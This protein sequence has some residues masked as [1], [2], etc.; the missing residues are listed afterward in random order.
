MPSQL[1]LDSIAALQEESFSAGRREHFLRYVPAPRSGIAPVWEYGHTDYDRARFFIAHFGDCVRYVPD[2]DIWRVWLSGWNEDSTRTRLPAYAFALRKRCM[3]QLAD[4]END[5]MNGVMGSAEASK[6]EIKAAESQI[7]RLKTV[8][9]MLADMANIE[10]MLKAA[11]SIAETTRPEDLWDVDPYCAGTSNGTLNL[12]TRE[13]GSSRFGDYITKYLGAAYRPG[14]T[15]PGW[16]QFLSRV[17]PDEALQNYLQALVGYTL[18]GDV[19]DQGFYFL[20]GKGANG[21]SVFL[22]MIS[23]LMGDYAEQGRRNLLEESRNGDPKHDLA[24]LPG[25]RFLYCEETSA[26]GK[27]REEVLKALTGGEKVVG[28]AKYEKPIVFQPVCKLW[29]AGNHRPAIEGTDLGIWRRVKLIPFTTTIPEEERIP[30]GEMLERLRPELSGI[31]NW[32]LDGL[33]RWR[34]GQMPAEVRS[35]VEEYRADEDDLADFVVDALDECPGK[36]VDRSSV[37]QAY[38]RWAEDQGIRNV[39][40]AKKFNRRLGERP[41][42]SS[43]TRKNWAGWAVKPETITI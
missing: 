3:E 25:K 30:Y 9:D 35:A 33:E 43:T 21:K 40:S 15:C 11:H 31:L 29:I 5:I 37:Y 7:K 10:S 36:L 24:M 27:L 32:A 18:T 16:M 38:R 23:E 1:D 28:E 39:W 17:Q 20:Y 42:F 8:C 19:S 13:F 6:S 4:A 34:P 2:R 41:G 12:R 26:G 14:E 22:R